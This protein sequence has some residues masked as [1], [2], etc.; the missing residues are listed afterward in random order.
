MGDVGIA[1]M[2]PPAHRYVVYFAQFSD[3]T[4][5]VGMAVS[6]QDRVELQVACIQEGQ[7]GVSFA[8]ID[9]GGVAVVV[10]GPDVVVVQGRD[11]NNFKH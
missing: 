3:A 9:H 4:G 7:N 8:G 11:C 5:V 6:A 10:D 1:G 2:S